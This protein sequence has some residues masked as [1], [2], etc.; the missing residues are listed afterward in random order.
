[1]FLDALPRY[2]SK[3]DGRRWAEILN[4]QIPNANYNAD[5]CWTKLN[6]L[7]KKP[8][9]MKMTVRNEKAMRKAYAEHGK[10]AG[11][12]VRKFWSAWQREEDA[13]IRQYAKMSQSRD[14]AVNHDG[15]RWKRRETK[16]RR[17][18]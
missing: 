3:E 15:K 4:R 2:H 10:A 5:T 16:R 8:C 18:G 17:G 14:V 6:N 1:M 7:K 11:P 13:I 9:P 12:E